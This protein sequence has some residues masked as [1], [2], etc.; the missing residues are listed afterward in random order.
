MQ[1]S[2]TFDDIGNPPNFNQ[3]SHH[4]SQIHTLNSIF[5]TYE[6]ILLQ[7]FSEFH[8]DSKY[9]IEKTIA[10]MSTAFLA[11]VAVILCI[12]FRLLNV[13]SQPMKPILWCFDECFLD[14]IY[15]IAPVLREP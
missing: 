12:L 13:S 8:Y 10:A 4:N 6:S 14:C 9:F 5:L 15:K 11:A 7:L 3:H 1:T 2:A